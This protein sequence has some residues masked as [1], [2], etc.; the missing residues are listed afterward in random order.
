MK[1]S[2]HINLSNLTD[3]IVQYGKE[4]LIR[5]EPSPFASAL[6]ADT[7]VIKPW[8]LRPQLRMVLT[9]AVSVSGKWS[10]RAPL[11]VERNAPSAAKLR[12][13]KLISE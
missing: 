10:M 1:S 5:S 9:S 12:A 6:S 3:K 8:S 2:H 4:N 11:T 7:W 13:S